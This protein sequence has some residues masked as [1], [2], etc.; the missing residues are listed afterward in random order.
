[1]RRQEH[2]TAAETA[3]YAPGLNVHIPLGTLRR[4]VRYAWCV[5]AVEAG[6]RAGVGAKEG[7]RGEVWHFETEA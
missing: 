6:A 3:W 5:D 7:R 1:M 4:G 2:G